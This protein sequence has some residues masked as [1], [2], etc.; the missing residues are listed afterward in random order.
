MTTAQID[1]G[2]SDAVANGDVEFEDD[3]T[4]TEKAYALQDAGLITLN[5]SIRK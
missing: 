3:L 4:T 5:R 1:S 2:Y